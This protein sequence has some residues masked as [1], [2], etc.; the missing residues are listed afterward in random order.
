MKK[1]DSI[2]I[3]KALG[4]MHA[5]LVGMQPGTIFVREFGKNVTK[6]YMFLLLFT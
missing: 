3:G 4:N 1:H 2:L 5:L 6:L